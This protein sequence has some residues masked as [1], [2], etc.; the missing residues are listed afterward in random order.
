MDD[1]YSPINRSLSFN[2]GGDYSNNYDNDYGNVKQV[3]LD[4]VPNDPYG[5]DEYY[6]VE[7]VMQEWQACPSDVAKEY[8]SVT[9][10]KRIQKGIQREIYNR[11]YGKFRLLEDQ[12]VL[13]LLTV[14]RTV[15][16]QYGKDLPKKIV[17]Q[18]KLLNAHTIEYVAPD[19][20]TNLKQ[21]Y[22]Y[23]D[24]IKNPPTPLPQPINVNNAGRNQLR[25]VAQI[26]GI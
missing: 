8:F 20:I 4:G 6:Y 19:M 21:H 9:N 24:D 12:N 22:G 7:Y 13:D 10:I 15:Y 14:M 11:S 3:A 1:N 25:G 2:N 26:W 17:R 5:V 23:L 16:D 18:V